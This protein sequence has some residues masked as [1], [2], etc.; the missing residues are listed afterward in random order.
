MAV[1]ALLNRMSTGFPENCSAS[2]LL[3]ATFPVSCSVTCISGPGYR[4]RD[5]DTKF[6]IRHA[7]QI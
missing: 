5:N 4:R 6:R 7:F 3:R 2:F 1:R